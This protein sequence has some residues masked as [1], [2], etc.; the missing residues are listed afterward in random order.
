MGLQFFSLLYMN[1]PDLALNNQ[2]AGCAM[3]PN[4]NKNQF[5]YYLIDFS[6]IW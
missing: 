5:A 1:K 6:L 4:Q 2:N 3:K